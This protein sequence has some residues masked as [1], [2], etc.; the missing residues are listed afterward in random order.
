MKGLLNTFSSESERSN[1]L[2]S[3]LVNQGKQKEKKQDKHEQ[4]LKHCQKMA[5]ECGATE[6]TVE[7]FC[8]TQLFL[9][10]GNRVMF[11][12]MTSNEARF[13][14]LKRW[15]QQKNLY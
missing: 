8:A 4:S 12:N 1:Q 5:M 10:K 15:C 2:I 6:D 9:E 13:L 7:Y 14:W 3:E 11:E